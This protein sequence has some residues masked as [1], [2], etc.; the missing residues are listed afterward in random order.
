[1]SAINV[2]HP[3]LQTVTMEPGV[4]MGQISRYLFKRGWT[5]PI[6]PELDILTVGVF[7]LIGKFATM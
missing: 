4:M 7:D 1:M 5:I 3:I 6:V 2:S